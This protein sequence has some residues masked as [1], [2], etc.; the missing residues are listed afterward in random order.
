MALTPALRCAQRISCTL[1]RENAWKQ[2]DDMTLVPRL[3]DLGAHLAT[4]TLIVTNDPQPGRII[5]R[6]FPDSVKF[7]YLLGV[8]RLHDPGNAVKVDVPSGFS[9]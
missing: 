3:A 5:S 9:I 6:V 4:E 1:H 2:C 7:E 8:P